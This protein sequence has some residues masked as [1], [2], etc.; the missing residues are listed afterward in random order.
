MKNYTIE[1]EGQIDFFK[2]FR[3]D[4]ENNEVLINN[5]DGVWNANIF[6]FKLDINNIHKAL[7]QA[8]KYLSKL[9]IKGQSVPS[10]ILLISLNESLCYHYQSKDFFDEIH[11]IYFGASSKDNE[12]FVPNSKCQPVKLNYSKSSDAIQ[13]KSLLKDTKYLPID[14][15]EN[16]IVG[17]AERYYRE[18]GTAKKGDFIGDNE[19]Q[20]KI[21]GEIREPVVFKGLINPYKKGSNEKFKYLMDKLNDNLS[22]KKLGAY[23]T[24]IVY[25][26]KTAE[27]VRMAISRVPKG[28]DYIILDRCAGTGNLEAVLSDE[29]LSHCILS[30]YEYYEY[31]VLMER[32]GDKVRY[33]LPPIESQV[34]YANGLITNAD[35]LSYEYIN[36]Q[37]LQDIV[38]NP[39]ITII[40][41]EN[42]PYHDSSSNT[43]IEDGDKKREQRLTEKTHML[44]LSSKKNFIF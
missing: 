29:E 32:L 26:E 27:L 7:F 23:Y 15:D 17:W 19:G 41:L 5:T 1:K 31:K 43:Y 39:K 12:D 34:A 42:P 25:C 10:N 14:I 30:T 35:A 24:P 18:V 4:Y 40:M 38:N 9:R 28:N 13:L 33:I 8:I 22:K 6:E 21:K 16:C 37:E 11:K 2:Q 20:V 44:L 3:I 36:C